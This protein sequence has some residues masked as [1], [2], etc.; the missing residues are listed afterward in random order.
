MSLDMDPNG[1]RTLTP[2]DA[3]ATARIL[4]RVRAV[5]GSRMQRGVVVAAPPK[6][7]SRPTT[8]EPILNTPVAVKW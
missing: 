1:H 3:V 6:A 8:V 7:A 5:T 4:R 2:G